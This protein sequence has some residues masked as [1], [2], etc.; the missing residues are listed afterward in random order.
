MK[1]LVKG[2]LVGI[3]GNAF[4][5]L[6]HFKRSAR[7]S[8]W[9]NAE[10]EKVINDAMSSDYNHLLYTIN[11]CFDDCVSHCDDEIDFKGGEYVP[12]EYVNEY[13]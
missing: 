9:P 8:G 12:N 13:A 5:I 7:R 2:T 3:D 4:A 6:G 1:Y 11:K 10:V